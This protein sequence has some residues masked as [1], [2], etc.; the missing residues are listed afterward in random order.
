MNDLVAEALHLATNGNR[1]DA[2]ARSEYTTCEIHRS[3]R[4]DNRLTMLC[5][6]TKVVS[7]QELGNLNTIRDGCFNIV[8]RFFGT[9]AARIV[10]FEAKDCYTTLFASATG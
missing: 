10:S 7:S 4:F 1:R 5:S 8:D 2:S 9:M 3:R 6:H